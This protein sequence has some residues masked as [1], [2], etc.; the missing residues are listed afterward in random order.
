[1]SVRA[2]DQMAIQ[3]ARPVSDPGPAAAGSALPVAQVEAAP[4]AA[5]G[6]HPETLVEATARRLRKRRAAVDAIRRAPEYTHCDPVARPRTPD[7]T[8]LAIPKRAWE[9]QVM[10]WRQGLKSMHEG[11]VSL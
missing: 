7:P 4:A 9:K 8:D 1:M 2:I 3:V 6:P 10:E 5:S 11:W